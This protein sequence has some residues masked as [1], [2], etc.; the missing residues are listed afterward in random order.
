MTVG[1]HRC[2]VLRRSYPPFTAFL[3]TSEVVIAAWGGV[4]LADIALRRRTT[5]S[6]RSLPRRPAT[7]RS[8]GGRPP[9]S[10]WLVGLG[11]RRQRE[12]FRLSW[13]ATS[14]GPLGGRDGD[15]AAPTSVSSLA[16]SWD[17]WA[18]GRQRRPRARG[19]NSSHAPTRRC[20]RRRA[21]SIDPR[22]RRLS[23]TRRRW[24]ARASPSSWD[25]LT[26]SLSSGRARPTPSTRRWGPRG[27]R[28][29]GRDPRRSFLPL[30]TGTAGNC[31]PT[32]ATGGAVLGDG[33]HP[34]LRGEWER[35]P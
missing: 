31:A 11:P 32:S 8:T 22:L 2:R 25:V 19:G 10:R 1:N 14:L 26:R 9:P 35:G 5:A 23:W 15:W 34:P 29:P 6:P 20:G 7:A 27:H 30:P 4:M 24:S 16:M 18:T 13:Q 12:R 28:V 21:V 17:S 3:T 33:A